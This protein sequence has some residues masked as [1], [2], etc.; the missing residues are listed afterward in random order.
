MSEDCASCHPAETKHWQQSHHARAMLPASADSVL[1]EFDG[2][3]TRF[4][5]Q[6]FRFIY[7]NEQY[8]VRVGE[9]NEA[10]TYPIDYVFGF[11]PLQQYLARLPGGRYQAIPVAWDT[12]PKGKGGQRWY[13]LDSDLNWDHPG[14]TWNTSCAECHSTKL[15]KGYQPYS[16]TF[17]T[18]FDAV[19]ITCAACHGSSEGHQQWLAAGQ[20]AQS[21]AGFS[22]TLK[23]RGQWLWLEGETIARRQGEPAGRQLSSC[24]QCHSLRQNIGEWH[25]DTRLT[26]HATLTLPNPP[27]YHADGQ[28]RE[29][30]FVMG[31]FLQSRMH[32]AGVVCSNCHE[33][34]SGELRAEGDAVC[35]QCHQP[36]TY[37]ATT[38]HRHQ[39]SD[40]HCVDCHMP[41]TVY[42]GVDARRDH[43]FGVPDPELSQQLGSPDPCLSCHADLSLEVLQARLPEAVTES[44]QRARTFARVQRQGFSDSDRYRLDSDYFPDLRE[45]SLLHL[46]SL[47]IATDRALLTSRLKDSSPLVRAAAIRAFASAPPAERWDL[48]SPLVNDRSRAV[49]M[50]LVPALAGAVPSA[51]A[52]PVRERLSQLFKDYEALMRANTDSPQIAANFANY[53]LAQGSPSQAEALFLR[54]IKLD[55]GFV[56]PYLQLSALAAGTPAEL[57][58]LNKAK[59]VDQ[60]G[61]ADYQRALYHVR[62]RDYQQALADF[63]QA[64]KVA[65]AREDFAYAYAIALENT[66]QINRALT[67]LSQLEARGHATTRSRDLQLRYLLKSGQ[68]KK[69]DEFLQQ[70][71]AREPDNPTAREWRQR[72]GR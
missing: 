23:E 63:E 70:W 3:V 19:N 28:I 25:P 17:V 34:H 58:W 31:S 71:L 15:E 54:A 40:M 48:L 49:Q 46:L 65:P 10:V 45:A 16:N 64:L 37:S 7:Q 20:P 24:G 42:M 43:R 69:A 61:E 72:S 52:A 9:G 44:Q 51:V 26:D 12:R 18:H 4:N 30:V 2:S 29:E 1:A 32:G 47:R 53:H 35:L 38:H 21:H 22:A 60:R 59:A 14:F 66:G 6:A 5:G 11:V 56:Y 68:R 33:P 13:A 50:E 39:V 55:P 57:D 8:Q 62:Q 36:A 27:H 67:V 41:A